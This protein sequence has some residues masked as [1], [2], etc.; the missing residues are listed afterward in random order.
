MP[1]KFALRKPD[2]LPTTL[3]RL[4][5]RFTTDQ[6]TLAADLYPLVVQDIKRHYVEENQLLSAEECKLHIANSEH[7]LKWL[8]QAYSAFNTPDHE[9]NQLATEHLEAYNGKW[10]DALLIQRLE[11]P[12]KLEKIQE[13]WNT[14]KAQ[15]TPGGRKVGVELLE[16]LSKLLIDLQVDLDRFST[17]ICGDM[18]QLN[19]SSEVEG[20]KLEIEKS[21]H[22][23]DLH[24]GDLDAR[25][26]QWPDAS[27]IFT[28]PPTFPSTFGPHSANSG[29]APPLVTSK[30]SSIHSIMNPITGDAR[31]D[32]CSASEPR[33][34]IQ[35]IL[36]GGGQQATP[37]VPIPPL[38]EGDSRLGGSISQAPSAPPSY[39]N[40]D[41]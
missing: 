23:I 9:V 31:N 14:A 40:P 7:L 29:V 2:P 33:M 17:H 25:R 8:R 26:P 6:N 10:G 41:D 18:Y 21:I 35:N 22:V 28:F 5:E 20:L 24:S 39:L 15:A 36:E 19:A 38:F 1:S 4:K 30:V 27:T 13:S 32:G 12:D 16:K 37:S 11:I 3:T 34:D